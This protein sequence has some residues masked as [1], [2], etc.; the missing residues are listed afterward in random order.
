MQNS[1]CLAE[2][3]IIWKPAAN[4]SYGWRSQNNGF[5]YVKLFV[6]KNLVTPVCL[7]REVCSGHG[8]LVGRSPLHLLFREGTIGRTS[9]TSSAICRL[10]ACQRGFPCGSGTATPLRE[11][12]SLDWK[13]RLL[14]PVLPS[15]PRHTDSQHSDWVRNC[16]V[17]ETRKCFIMW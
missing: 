12:C 6:F 11:I 17:A 7:I 9:R 10:T 2:H 5:I 15:F 14:G 4:Q 13:R 3:R 16:S 8:V 1:L